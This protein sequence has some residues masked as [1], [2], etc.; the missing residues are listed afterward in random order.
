MTERRGAPLADLLPS[1]ELSL[2]ERQLSKRTIEVYQRTGHQLVAFLAEH[3]LPADTEGIDAPHL[4]A[5]L[6]AEATRTS[7]IS[8][9]QHYRNL[10]V[11]FKWLIRED[12]RENP[13]PMLRVDP[14]RTTQK[15]KPLLSED[16]LT[17]L[18]RTC[19]GKTFEQRRDMAILRVLIDTG[20][21][22]SG[23]GDILAADVNLSRKTIK[24]RLKGGDE[25]LIPLGTRATAAMDRYLR[26]RARHP[27]ALSPW[28]WLGM[29]GRRADHLGAAGIQDV[30]ERRARQAGL[31][32]ITPHWFRRTA[33]HMLLDAGMQ[34]EAVARVLGWKSTAMVR[35]YAGALADERAR[36]A[37][38]R[39][40][41]G[42]RI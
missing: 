11:L 32:K 10:R 3:G 8:A 7:A 42:D 34:D 16:D 30:I 39:L 2:A 36:A 12:E 17:A 4:R 31:P 20:G 1:W 28:L 41:P 26:A 18:L 35:R 38:A 21:R 19:E 5:F 23:V 40:N 33:T 9:H 6:A 15:I 22:V 13:D 25:H 14:P 29:A 24:I 37:H 27:R